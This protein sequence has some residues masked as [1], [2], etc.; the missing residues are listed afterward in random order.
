[1]KCKCKSN[2]FFKAKC[3]FFLIL[4]NSVD[5]ATVWPAMKKV[6]KQCLA[7]QLHSACT[8]FKSISKDDKN[9]SQTLLIK[10]FNC[11]YMQLLQMYLYHHFRSKRAAWKHLKIKFTLR[12]CVFSSRSVTEAV[13]IR[14]SRVP[15]S[16][17]PPGD[18]TNCC[19][20]CKA[21]WRHSGNGTM[22]WAQRAPPHSLNT[23]A[24][25]KI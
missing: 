15:I 12:I 24:N 5:Q 6:L 11:S 16:S 8:S 2:G 3:S 1:M 10:F 18:R 20:M 14:P 13:G 9:Y 17:S 25:K 23:P 22:L 19:T 4:A 21:C 7:S